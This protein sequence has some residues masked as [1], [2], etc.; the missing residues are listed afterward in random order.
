[1]NDVRIFTTPILDGLTITEYK[2]LVVARNVRAVNVFRDFFTGVRD[3]I[4]GRS[5]SYQKVMDTMQDEVIQEAK[6]RARA[7]GA[8]AIVGFQLDFDNISSKDRSLLMVSAKGTA[9]VVE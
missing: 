3:I 7:V 4:G 2:G 1:M 9:V 6:E 5:G 8:N